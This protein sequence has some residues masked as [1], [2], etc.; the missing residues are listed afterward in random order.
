MQERL[1][2]LMAHAGIG[3]RRTCEKMIAAGRVRV[4]GSRAELGQKADP[5]VDRVEVDGRL[6]PLAEDK[7]YIV[8]HKP[9]GVLSTVRTP[10][11]VSTVID[12]VDHPARLYPVGRL[13]RNSEGLMLLTN[14]G[15]LAYRLSHPKFHHVKEYR[16]LVAAAPTEEQLERWR[17]GVEMP[18]GYRVRPVQVRVAG[19]KGKGAWLRIKMGEGRKR[20]IRETC[21][22]LGLPVVR[23]IR[24]KLGP[25]ELGSLPSGSWRELKRDE[26]EALLRE[27]A[28]DQVSGDTD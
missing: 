13:D 14:D 5:A 27:T 23:I 3:S 4:N 11:D 1:Q 28:A 21:R 15:E 7:V 24:V 22:V 18:D 19:R 17:D 8:L 20:Q 2:K 10:E 12:L 26:V 16:V 9:Q 25:L 6:L